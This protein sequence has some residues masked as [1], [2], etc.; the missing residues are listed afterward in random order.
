MD[1]EKSRPVFNWAMAMT[2]IFLSLIAGGLIAFYL[3]TANAAYLLKPLMTGEQTQNMFASYVVGLQGQNHLQV[4]RLQ[5]SE[6]F[7]VTS[8]KRIL[9]FFPG[10]TVEI[11]ARVPCQIVYTVALKDAE[12]RFLVKDLGKRLIVIAP[13]LEFNRPAVDLAKYELRVDK[14]SLIRDTEEVKALLQSQ[15][16][17]YLDE[18]GR[19]NRDSV[20][21]TARLAIKDFIENWLLNSL[22]GK[23][24]AQ[25]VVDRVF[26][27]DE[28]PLYRQFISTDDN[29]GA[30]GE[31]EGMRQG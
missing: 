29:H 14:S 27:K 10:G 19:K 25:P 17:D 28:E 21:D 8:E 24:L 3:L 31:L 11:S 12:W 5:T 6:E 13:D 4:A 15:I 23:D 9:N 20:R 7:A 18:V 2:V 26:F 1:T 16:P 22:K 30:N